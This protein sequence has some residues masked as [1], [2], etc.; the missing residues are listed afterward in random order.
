MSAPSTD[1]ENTVSPPELSAAELR[2]LYLNGVFSQ[3][4]DSLTTGAVLIGLALQLGASHLMIGVIGAIPFLSN[5]FQLPAIY[6]IDRIGDRKKIVVASS[7][8]GRSCWLLVALVPLV[9]PSSLALTLVVVAMTLR[10]CFGAFTACAWNSWL[11]DIIPAPRLGRFLAYRLSLMSVAAV[12]T[13]LGAAALIDLWKGEAAQLYVYAVLFTLGSAAGLMG[14]CYS[15]KVPNATLESRESKAIGRTMRRDRLISPFKHHN[16]RRLMSFLTAWHFAAN[17]A[18]PFF[19]VYM[20]TKLHYDLTFVI[21]LTL[22]GQA[23]T[24]A[25]FRLWGRYADLFSHKTVMAACGGLFIMCLFGWTFTSFP[26]RHQYT[27]P[28][29]FLL[30]ALMGFATAGINLA[31]SSLALKLAPQ[32]EAT[33]FLA[34]NSMVTS[35]A[36]GMAPLIGGLTADFFAER[37]LSLVV[38]WQSSGATLDVNTLHVG[39]WDFF[40]VIAFFTGLF[41]LNRLSLVQEP[42][43][44]PKDVLIRELMTDTSQM[45]RTFTSIDGLRDAVSAPFVMATNLIKMTPPNEPTPAPQEP[46]DPPSKAS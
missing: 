11:R 9:Y 5:L 41:A 2:P 13:G 17:L 3:T 7:M 21:A 28:L 6:L 33:S 18:T 35:L 31:T 27:T 38:R 32:R 15:M 39:Q 20:L 37:Q 30:H 46:V 26:E 24:A 23:I 1:A 22:F 8:I 25:S 14:A 34:V 42:G 36:A 19:V 44:R 12:A 16:F 10:Y 45:L 4:M 40:F 29:L 43:H